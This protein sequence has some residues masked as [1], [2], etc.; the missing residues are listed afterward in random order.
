[1]RSQSS[2]S[3]KKW[4]AFQ[5]TIGI[6]A[7]VILGAIVSG[8][9]SFDSNLW[10]PVRWRLVGRGFSSTGAIMTEKSKINVSRSRV[11]M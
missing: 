2:I 4:T 5:I 3:I 1:M 7:V 6:F 8:A 11:V 9:Q 10:K